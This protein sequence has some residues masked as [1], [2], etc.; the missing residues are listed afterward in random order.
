VKPLERIEVV[1]I[2]ADPPSAKLAG[3]L[4]RDA[5]AAVNV[6]F[7]AEQGLRL[8]D[9]FRPRGVLLELELP[10]I[11]GLV[12]ARLISQL[13]WARETRIIGVSA[14]NGRV[15]LRD[16]LAHGCAAYVQKPFD[17]KFMTTVVEVL[18]SHK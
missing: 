4:L 10:F 16:A 18:R 14:G 15:T 3:V 13:G 11:S 12:L 8:V 17:E 6:A 9:T 5:G 7:D 2:D 1:V